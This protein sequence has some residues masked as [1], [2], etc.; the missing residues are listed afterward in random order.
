MCFSEA[1]SLSEL[2]GSNDLASDL[3]NFYK[4]QVCKILAYHVKV[5]ESDPQ[6]R[7]NVRG[8][9][10]GVVIIPVTWDTKARGLPVKPE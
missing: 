3:R 7:Q 6:P 9:L 4:G 2:L 8:Y 10:M 1:I 5:P